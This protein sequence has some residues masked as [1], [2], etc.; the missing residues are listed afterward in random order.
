MK[1]VSIVSREQESRLV[2]QAK[3]DISA[4]EKLYEHYLPK[5]YRYAYYRM[6]SSYE[7]EDIVSQT[8]LLA[9]ENLSKYQERGYSFGSWLYRIASNVI[10]DYRRKNKTENKL[11]ENIDLGVN[12]KRIENT[13]EKL[14][15]ISIL[16]TLPDTQQQVLIL[17]YI[18]DLSLHQVAEIMDKTEGA[19]KQLAFRGLKS[20]R[21]R[22]ISYDR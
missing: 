12:D 6:N 16:H 18:E 9:L 11:V 19:V 7:A 3:S 4:F 22:M 5:L 2:E 14:A 21:E 1:H 15:I 13:S 17:R 20:M 10:V 8:F